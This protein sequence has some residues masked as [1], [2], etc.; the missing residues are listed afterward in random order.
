MAR[1]PEKEEPSR[2]LEE[3]IESLTKE[4]SGLINAA[5]TKEREELRD[6]AVSK[7]GAGATAEDVYRA[8]VN[9]NNAIASSVEKPTAN[10]VAAFCLCINRNRSAANKHSNRPSTME[11]MRRIDE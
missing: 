9:G 7:Y 11:S 10:L 4:L 1:A 2:E 6:Y 5:G 8:F 3:K